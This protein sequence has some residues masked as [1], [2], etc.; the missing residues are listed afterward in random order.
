[1]F[2]KNI[3]VYFKNIVVYFKNV[4]QVTSSV[5]PTQHVFTIQLSNNKEIYRLKI[6]KVILMK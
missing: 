4:N 2:F 6:H 1:M 3:V 5:F